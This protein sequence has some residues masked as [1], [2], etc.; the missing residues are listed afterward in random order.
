M[1]ITAVLGAS[2]N[3]DRFSYKAVEMLKSYGHEVLAFGR[4]SGKIN[5][6]HI[7]T[8]WQT[9]EKVHTVTLYLRPELQKPHYNFIFDLQPQRLIF[10]PGTEN[11]EL[12]DLACKKNIEV[13]EACTLVMLSR[14]IY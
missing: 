1:K 13:V 6:S 3:P 2:P 4:R 7:R 5:E 11:P 8:D 12:L 10:N 9:E 14:N